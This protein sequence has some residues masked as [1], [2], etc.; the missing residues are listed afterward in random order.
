[1][2]SGA[3]ATIFASDRLLSASEMPDERGGRHFGVGTAG[4]GDRGAGCRPADGM[5]R[6]GRGVQA[7]SGLWQRRESI[8]Y[9][10]GLSELWNH[11]RIEKSPIARQ[12]LTRGPAGRR[13]QRISQPG[14]CDSSATC[15]EPVG[16]CYDQDRYVF[17]SLS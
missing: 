7:G 17:R 9:G 13:G 6:N 5:R 11:R 1:M 12:L 3:I 15:A 2:A 10:Q 16:G 14:R 4:G 8:G